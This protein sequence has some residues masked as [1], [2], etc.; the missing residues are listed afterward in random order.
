MCW[1]VGVEE[2]RIGRYC[3][4]EDIQLADVLPYK[5]QDIRIRQNAWKNLQDSNIEIQLIPLKIQVTEHIDPV[6]IKTGI[7]AYSYNAYDNN[8]NIE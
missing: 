4:T 6:R 8:V 1:G 2:Y 3:A 5:T 7:S